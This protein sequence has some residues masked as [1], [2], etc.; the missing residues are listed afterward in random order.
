[1]YTIYKTYTYILQQSQLPTR[2]F[3]FTILWKMTENYWKRGM[4]IGWL[5]V[6]KETNMVTNM[7][8]TMSTPMEM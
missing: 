4:V 6:G 1:M 3:A 5:D 7:Q 8:T 2:Y